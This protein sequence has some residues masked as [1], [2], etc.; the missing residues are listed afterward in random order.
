MFDIENI[1]SRHGFQYEVIRTVEYADNPCLFVLENEVALIGSRHLAGTHFF[2]ALK[3]IFENRKKSTVEAALSKVQ[4][5][6]DVEVI[7]CPDGT[8]SFRLPIDNCLEEDDFLELLLARVKELREFV[9][10]V[11]N[12]NGLYEADDFEMAQIRQYFIY[13]TI[14]TALQL[15]RLPI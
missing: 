15:S 11:E 6:S 2:V 1:L 9:Q 14:D 7:S 8:W 3:R 13:E 5:G 4:Y 10:S 12:Q